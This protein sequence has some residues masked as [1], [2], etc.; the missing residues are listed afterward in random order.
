FN[1]DASNP[2]EYG[3]YYGWG[4][5][6]PYSTT[7]NVDWEL[8]FKMIGGSGN[9]ESDCGKDKDPLASIAM[10]Q[11]VKNISGSKWDAAHVKLGGK[12]RMPTVAE[13][14]E[15]KAKCI[16]SNN[17]SNSKYYICTSNNGNSI[18]LPTAGF[19]NSDG[20]GGQGSFYYWSSSSYTND[21]P[22]YAAYYKGTKI[23]M[24]SS[25]RYIGCPIRPVWDDNMPEP[26]EI[27]AVDL[28][29]PS[30]T[31]WA[32]IN[33]GASTIEE[34]G[35][36]YGWG[37]V[38]P[39]STTE[40]VDWPIYFQKLGKTGTAGWDNKKCGT[41]DDPL[42]D[43]VNYDNPMS[44]DGTKYDAAHEKCGGNWHIPTKSDWDELIKNCTWTWQGTGYKVTNNVNGN[45]IFLPAGGKHF[46]G[47]TD[48]GGNTGYY[49]CASPIQNDPNNVR[50]IYE[51]ATCLYFNSGN[52]ILFDYNYL[53]YGLRCKGF[54]IR[55]V[56]K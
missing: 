6:E 27:K 47:I 56:M 8:Y 45:Y 7:D 30:G 22:K 3:G 40:Y 46:G 41:G 5:I 38:E 4:C 13:W 37:C 53:D 55:P 16:L 19:H 43:Y 11:G 31:K 48:K 39:Y 42:K 33:L 49:W 24:Y 12:W 17:T 1:L 10:S 51:N 2:E 15:L 52:L 34:P 9:S 26:T 36:Y 28:G 35:D 54:T 44:I 32:N 14:E 50:A 23:G 18:I 25:R 20:E 29:L 21:D